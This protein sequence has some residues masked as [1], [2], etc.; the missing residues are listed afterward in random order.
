M[1]KF[2]FLAYTMLHRYYKSVVSLGEFKFRI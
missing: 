1:Y 2:V